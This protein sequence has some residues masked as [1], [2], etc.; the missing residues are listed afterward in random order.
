MP[1]QR[2]D[3]RQHLPKGAT[4]SVHQRLMHLLAQVRPPEG[5]LCGL[6]ERVWLVPRWRHSPVLLAPPARVRSLLT[7][8]IG[9]RDPWRASLR[10]KVERCEFG[11]SGR[12]GR[13]WRVEVATD[14]DRSIGVR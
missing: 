9:P 1:C 12:D 5:L 14:D 3:A 11:T 2:D 10:H 13:R 8:R 7:A 6:L 4:T